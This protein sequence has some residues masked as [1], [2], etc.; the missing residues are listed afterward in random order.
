MSV[1]VQNSINLIF[2][3]FNTTMLESF[4][5]APRVWP[6]Y[7]MEVPSSSR[8][9][10]HGW[11]GDQATVKECLVPETTVEQVHFRMLRAAGIQIYRHPGVHFFL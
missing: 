2:Q 7:C 8:S 6:A 10:L 4:N 1:N 3:E 9:T 11:L 5:A